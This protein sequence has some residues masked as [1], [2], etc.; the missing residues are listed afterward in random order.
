MAKLEEK[1]THCDSEV[2]DSA[3]VLKSRLLA[4]RAAA[5]AQRMPHFWLTYGSAGG[6]VG[7]VIMEAPSVLQ[8]RMNAAVCN[9]AAG[10]PFAEGHELSARL[11]AS[12][13]STQVGRMLSGAE[14]GELIRRL[15]ARHRP[16]ATATASN[17]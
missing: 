13:P 12:V 8:A 10:A 1:L 14:A 4:L 9:I 2:A 15:D 3:P 16:A 17:G 6:L 11:M 5:P 7:V